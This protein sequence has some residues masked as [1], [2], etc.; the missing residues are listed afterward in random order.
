MEIPIRY[1]E[2]LKRAKNILATFADRLEHEE[3]LGASVVT[4]LLDRFQR[5]TILFASCLANPRKMSDA[6]G[7]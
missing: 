3:S 7:I 6:V 2:L 4:A 5:D 1:D